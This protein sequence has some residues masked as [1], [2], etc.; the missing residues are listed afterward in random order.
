MQLLLSMSSSL[1]EDQVEKGERK[2][3]A[4]DVVSKNVNQTTEVSKSFN[5]AE[6]PNQPNVK[7]VNFTMEGKDLSILLN[8]KHE[9]AEFLVPMLPKAA[10]HLTSALRKQARMSRRMGSQSLFQNPMGM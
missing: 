8:P 7:I 4:I 9:K 2:D 10:G 6:S 3:H 1:N 5:K